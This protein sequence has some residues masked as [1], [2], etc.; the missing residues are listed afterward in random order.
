MIDI[1]R[2]YN[3]SFTFQCDFSDV[4]KY[5]LPKLILRPIQNLHSYFRYINNFI[6]VTPSEE[7]RN[8]FYQVQGLLVG[9]KDRLKSVSMVLPE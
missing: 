8:S 3:E 5:Y 4:F 7:D 9:L 2:K 1:C 6:R